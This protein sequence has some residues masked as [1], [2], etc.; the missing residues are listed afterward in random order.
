MSETLKVS[1]FEKIEGHLKE[2]I[3][4]FKGK[5]TGYS[6]IR[7]TH[8]ALIGGVFIGLIAAVAAAIFSKYALVGCGLLLSSVCVYGVYIIK[9]LYL[10]NLF[11]KSVNNFNQ[12][13][14]NLKKNIEDL[15]S[16][17]KTIQE[18]IEKLDVLN[19][20]KLEEIKNQKNK[21]AELTKTFEEKSLRFKKAEELVETF[22]PILDQLKN[23]ITHFIEQ[24][25]PCLVDLTEDQRTS[26]T[27]LT[28]FKADVNVTSL[29][30][31]NEELDKEITAIRELSTFTH[32]MLEKIHTIFE[33]SKQQNAG[34]KQI[35][36]KLTEEIK[37]LN[38]LNRV[39]TAKSQNLKNKEIIQK[40][41]KEKFK[42]DRKKVETAFKQNTLTRQR[43]EA[44]AAE[45][46]RK[47]D[48]ERILKS[49][50]S[51]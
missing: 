41:R 33:N 7:L 39:L 2:K 30:K 15:N 18:N 44:E 42:L 22:Y 32:G 43:K 11:E 10:I 45:A 3:N 5:F 47:S 24:T 35:S 26:Q 19:T 8:N 48:S 38:Q 46:I 9:D 27:L 29:E 50:V 49:T 6:I 4:S 21:F 23:T 14:T 17:N 37:N 28:K 20:T 12:D 25:T 1:I 40:E 51:V 34:N 16:T 36:S 31:G 13:I